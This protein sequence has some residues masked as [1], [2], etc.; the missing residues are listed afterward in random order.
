MGCPTSFARPSPT[1]EGRDR[2]PPP[3]SARKCRQ[4]VVTCPATIEQL[5]SSTMRALDEVL[6]WPHNIPG[7]IDVLGGPGER[8]VASIEVHRPDSGRHA[9]E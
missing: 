3:Y 4:G 9:P 1:A 2:N 5:T 6:G 7:L 8:H